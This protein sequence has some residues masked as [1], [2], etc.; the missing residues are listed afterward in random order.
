MVSTIEIFCCYAREDQELLRN[1]KKH[2]MPLQR[3]ALITIWSDTDINAGATWEE[4]IDKH[5]NTAHIILLLVS[6]D[7]MDSEYC[8]SKEMKQAMQRHERGE[9]RVIPILLRPTYW[10]GAPFDK[11]QALP[12]N[13]KP[14]TDHSWHTED[15]AL[16]D[17]AEQISTVVKELRIQNYMAEADQLYHEQR[18]DEALVM[19][20]QLLH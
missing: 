20:D 5:L 7:F 18:Y 14:V 9:A 17:V 6:S 2:L 13:A 3:Q 16:Y 4:E 1:L 19:Y 8:Y 15:S 10:K 12:T 11:L